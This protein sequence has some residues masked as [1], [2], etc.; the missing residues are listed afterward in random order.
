[1][2]ASLRADGVPT[3]IYYPRPLHLQPAYREHHDGARLPVSED[4]AQ[5]I[6]ALPIHADLREADMAHVCDRVLAALV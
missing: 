6:L 5:R 4:L 2:Q 3:A 1:V